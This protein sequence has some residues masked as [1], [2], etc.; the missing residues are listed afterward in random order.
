MASA[1]Q[2]QINFPEVIPHEDFN[3][4]L[5]NYVS[6]FSIALRYISDPMSNLESLAVT[7]KLLKE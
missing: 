6:S 7:L 3:E 1:Y 4:Q 2:L 5:M